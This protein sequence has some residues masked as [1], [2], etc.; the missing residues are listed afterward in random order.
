P[1]DARRAQAVADLAAERGIGVTVLHA[2]GASPLERL[3]SLVA[4]P[5]FTSVYLA[6]AHG[7]DPIAVPAVTEMKERTAP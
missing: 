4:V 3:A 1:L 6:L 7:L 5:D 2:E